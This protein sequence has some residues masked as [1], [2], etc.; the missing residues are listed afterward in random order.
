MNYE[1]FNHLYILLALMFAFTSFKVANC[2]P[3]KEDGEKFKWK[4]LLLGTIRHLIVIVG[5]VVVFVVSSLY[6]ADLLLIKIGDTNVTLQ[7]A[8]DLTTLAILTYYGAK[9]I[10]NLS[11]F[12]GISKELPEI[13]RV[14]EIRNSTDEIILDYNVPSEEIDGGQG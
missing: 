1:F 5:T 8:I 7:S 6:G 2:K 13:N 10:K 11:E 4:K 3:F 12:A 14:D 9:Y